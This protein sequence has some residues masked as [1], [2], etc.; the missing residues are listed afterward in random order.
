MIKKTTLKITIIVALLA[1][2]V[3]LSVYSTY[4]IWTTMPAASVIFEMGVINENASLKYQ[5]FVPINSDNERIE[6]GYDYSTKQYTLSNPEESV[7]IVGLAFVGLEAGISVVYMEI[8]DEYDFNIDGV[9][10]TF[11]VK[12]VLV[13]ADYRNY[14]L[15]GN[16][17]LNKIII[18]QNVEYIASGAFMSM[19]NLTT[20]IIRGTGE[21]L[22]GEYSFANCTKLTTPQIPDGRTLVGTKYFG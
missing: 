13:D 12:A 21:I 10:A 3:G 7:D 17:V 16:T 20:L 15:R 1:A 19:A 14:Y 6:G 2:L 8:P 5:L 4:A 18:P 11:P 9:T 22:L